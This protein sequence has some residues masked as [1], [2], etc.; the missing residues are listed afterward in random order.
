MVGSEYVCLE[1]WCGIS[2]YDNCSGNIEEKNGI[3]T[4][5]A[6]EKFIRKIEIE[7]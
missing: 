3:E 4:L 1:P 2:D 5:E 7:M 6:K